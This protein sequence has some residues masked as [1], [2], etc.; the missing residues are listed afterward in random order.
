MQATFLF[1]YQN[2][3]GV[4]KKNKVDSYFFTFK[5]NLGNLFIKKTIRIL[6][7]NLTQ[8]VELQKESK[9]LDLFNLIHK[10]PQPPTLFLSLVL[11]N[12]IYYFNISNFLKTVFKM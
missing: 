10:P 3:Q 9:C 12:K 2:M 5:D 7:V 11:T 6:I 1:C 4:Q 8:H